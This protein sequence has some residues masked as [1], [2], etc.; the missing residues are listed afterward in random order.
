MVNGV[1][2]SRT[3][4]H[5]DVL[6]YVSLRT[7]LQYGY[8]TYNYCTE[9]TYFVLNTICFRRLDVI[10]TVQIITGLKTT[11]SPFSQILMPCIEPCVILTEMRK[12]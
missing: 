9:D 2:I 8:N 11:P 1:R 12:P 5:Y 4:P 3:D 7:V 6:L 10:Y